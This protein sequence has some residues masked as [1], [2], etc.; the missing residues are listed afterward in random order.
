MIQQRIDN[1]ALLFKV[2]IT[3]ADAREKGQRL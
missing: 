1:E 3:G 2:R